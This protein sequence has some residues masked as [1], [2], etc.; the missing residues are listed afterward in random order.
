MSEKKETKNVVEETVDKVVDT[1]KEVVE[2]VKDK[3]ED[4]V[5][6]VDAPARSKKATWW[7]RIWSAIVGAALAVASMFG[8]TTAQV[9]EQKAKTE[10]VKATV[11]A[12]IEDINAGKVAEAKAKLESAVTTTKEV[13]AEA[14]QVVDNM[15]NADSKEVTKKAVD[16]ATQAL[17]KTAETTKTVETT[18]K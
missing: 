11:S 12:A 14:K 10:E 16:G 5:K 7:N 6:V 4:V 18:K 8:I 1:G 3:V 9:N 13:V 15:K 2:T 17:K